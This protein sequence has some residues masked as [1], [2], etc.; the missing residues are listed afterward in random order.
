MFLAL[1]Q[2][3]PP[4][5]P[6]APVVSFGGASPEAILAGG[7][8]VMGLVLWV[9]G[10]KL[11]KPAVVLTGVLLGAIVGSALAAGLKL[12]DFQGIPAPYAGLG[13]GG[14]L[15]LGLSLALFRVAVAGIAGVGLGA[16]AAAAAALA[17]GV[18]PAQTASPPDASERLARVR[19]QIAAL[20]MN[21]VDMLRQQLAGNVEQRSL[22]TAEVVPVSLRS[23]S[24]EVS[25]Q[26]AAR[27][28]ALG[29]EPRLA[30]LAGGTLGMLIGGIMGLLSP[31]RG[32]A[33]VTAMIG[34]GLWIGAGAWLTDRY[35]ANLAQS[36]WAAWVLAHPP[37][38]A[39]IWIMLGLI[40]FAAQRSAEPKPAPVAPPPPRPA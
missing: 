26:V 9:S 36:P 18:G 33:L 11:L 8:L 4:A 23:I 21:D 1:I 30:L 40:G 14:L 32:G 19:E 22:P 5:A 13:L 29:S 16:C 38:W 20:S 15:G 31:K 35:A 7:V 27:W 37:A 2:D 10:G 6:T 25:D 28:A 34:A 3:Q 39:V 17:V 24:T 12:P